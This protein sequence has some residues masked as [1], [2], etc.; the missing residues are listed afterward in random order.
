[1]RTN[2]YRAVLRQLTQEEAS[3]SDLAGT[4]PGVQEGQV[5]QEDPKTKKRLD[6][7]TMRCSVQPFQSEVRLGS[8]SDG[9]N[10]LS[11]GALLALSDLELD[12]LALVEGL[13]AAALDLRVVNEHIR[14]ATFLLDESEALFTVEPLDTALSHNQMSE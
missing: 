1:M 9:A 10:V 4:G 13:V 12:L 11:L 7:G 14:S 6:A 3:A 8:N 5:D 2:R